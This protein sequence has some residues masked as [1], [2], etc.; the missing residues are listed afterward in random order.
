MAM[1][2]I[3]GNNPMMG[4]KLA[5]RERGGWWVVAQAALLVVAIGL[6]LWAKPA[7]IGGPLHPVRLTG[8]ALVAFGLILAVSAMWK[9]GPL[10]T[11]YPRPLKEGEFCTRGPYAW[12]RHPIYTGIVLAVLG[13]SVQWESG[14]GVLYSVVVFLFLDRKASYEESFLLQ[15]YPAYADYRKRTRKFFPGIY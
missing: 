14:A 9:L 8:W 12:V 6:P 7:I 2:A 3:R 4:E 11:P 5:F 15:R 10:M 1:P 13:W